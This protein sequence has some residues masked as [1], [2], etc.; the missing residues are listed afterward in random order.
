LSSECAATSH[1]RAPGSE[2]DNQ[3]DVRAQE[4]GLAG[5][6]D[7]YEYDIWGEHFSLPHLLV[8]T[9]N[10]TTHMK[11]SPVNNSS[12]DSFFVRGPQNLVTNS[13]EG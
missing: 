6:A 7:E 4:A 5:L 12:F 3:K 10:V 8:S 13:Q 9:K 2:L 1:A 11:P